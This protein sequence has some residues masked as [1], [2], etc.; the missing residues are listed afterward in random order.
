[1]YM[2][3]YD[4]EVNSFCERLQERAKDKR[5]AAEAEYEAEEKKK[6]IA[7]SPGG[8]DPQEVYESLPE[9]SLKGI[10]CLN[11]C[12]LRI[13]FFSGPDAF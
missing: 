6:R 8:L 3:M 12:F 11:S 9:V 2:K 5:E 10:F 13:L 1:M 7:A 4:D